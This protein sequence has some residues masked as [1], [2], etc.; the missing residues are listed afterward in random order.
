MPPKKKWKIETS[1]IKEPES[2]APKQTE[3]TKNTPIGKA[4][5]QDKKEGEEEIE[6]EYVRYQGVDYGLL[7]NGSLH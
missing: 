4:E 5:G 6:A 7:P 2:I 3:S 1:E